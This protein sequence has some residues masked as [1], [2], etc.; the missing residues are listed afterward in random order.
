MV[1]AKYAAG[2][3]AVV[4]RIL[5]ALRR[6]DSTDLT[7]CYC[8]GNF[9]AISDG[10]V[11]DGWDRVDALLRASHQALRSLVVESI[12]AERL[13]VLSDRH[14]VHTV[15]FSETLTG[16]DGSVQRQ[17]VTWTHLL[18]RVRRNW[19]AVQSIA[20]HREARPVR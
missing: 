18:H 9:C 17:E 11:I 3:R 10:Q 16:R 1:D 4:D 6:L 19:L 12:E 5:G 13:E 8:K 20:S 7:A 14:A 2:V 15:I